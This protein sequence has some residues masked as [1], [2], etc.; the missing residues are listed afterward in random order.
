MYHNKI[1]LTAKAWR[2][3]YFSLLLL[4][5]LFTKGFNFLHNRIKNWNNNIILDCSSSG[6]SSHI[7]KLHNKPGFFVFCYIFPTDI[8]SYIIATIKDY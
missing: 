7:A 2:F 4:H 6:E 8:K 5:R 1:N 3:E